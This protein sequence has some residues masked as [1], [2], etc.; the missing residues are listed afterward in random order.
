[1]A[2]QIGFLAR[3]Y[4][5]LAASQMS[6]LNQST[7]ESPSHRNARCSAGV[8]VAEITMS[9]LVPAAFLGKFG[10]RHGKYMSCC[11]MFR[12]D[13]VPKDVYAAIVIV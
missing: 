5:G 1:M 11:L 8:L 4:G 13:V 2:S 7:S 10:P 3:A 12:G 6:A 9:V